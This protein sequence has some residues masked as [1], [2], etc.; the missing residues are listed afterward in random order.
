MWKRFTS[1]HFVGVWG[2]YGHFR[3]TCLE[4]WLQIDFHDDG[5]NDGILLPVLSLMASLKRSLFAFTLQYRCYIVFVFVQKLHLSWGKSIKLLPPKLLS[6][7]QMCTAPNC[8][9]TAT[10]PHISLGS[11]QRPQTLIKV[12]LGGLLLRI[13]KGGKWEY[14]NTGEERREVGK[15]RRA[16]NLTVIPTPL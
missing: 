5:H 12:Y 15:V 2:R 4:V 14:E 10:S 13:T 1:V 6:L 3:C 9:S 16:R 8:L 7:T 11:L